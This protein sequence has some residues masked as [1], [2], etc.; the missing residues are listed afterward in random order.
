[1]SPVRESAEQKKK[2]ARKIA[3]KL[4]QIYPE[5]ETA[6][7]HGDALEL[8]VATILSAQ[9]TDD[10][11]NQVTPHL[12]RRYRTAADYAGADPGEMEAII[13]STGF[14]RQKTKSLIRLGRALFEDFGGNV[15]DRLEDLVKLPGI[16]RKTANVVLGT[17][18]GIPG[19][20]V[21]T[22]V[23]R[24]SGRL[25]L[26]NE[27]DPVKIE[28]ALM[29]LLPKNDWTFGS[30]ALIW[31]GRRVCKARRPACPDCD[32]DPLCP[33]PDKTGS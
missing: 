17:W 25:G 28:F 31:H 10:R 21:D 8:L 16:G 2:R 30:H 32:L 18:F 33:W 23:K 4:H 22:H 29:E 5:A 7:D 13:K 20:T 26:T 1:M 9:C 11:V 6:L 3:R 12:F 14:F 27:T 24:L 19:I 15:P